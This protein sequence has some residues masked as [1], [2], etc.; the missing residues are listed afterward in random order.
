MNSELNKLI[1]CCID[2][3]SDFNI[4]KTI[5]FILKNKFKKT[6]VCINFVLQNKYI[7]LILY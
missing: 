2:T 3:D 1:D 4:S 5:Y 7:N 6:N